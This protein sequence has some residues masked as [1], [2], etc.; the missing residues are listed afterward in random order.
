[1]RSRADCCAAAEGVLSVL[2]H[3]FM[4]LQGCSG[5]FRVLPG[6]CQGVAVQ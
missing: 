2:L 5:Y 6:G 3:I 1:M 4:Q